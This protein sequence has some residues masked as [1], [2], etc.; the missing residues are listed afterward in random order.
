MTPDRCLGAKAAVNCRGVYSVTVPAKCA[1]SWWPRISC[2]QGW[3]TALKKWC[4]MVMH[5]YEQTY[6]NLLIYI[7]IGGDCENLILSTT[8][9]R[10]DMLWLFFC[11]RDPQCWRGFPGT[12]NSG[13]THFY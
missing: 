3:A 7:T 9:Q 11:A 12:A 1:L 5:N 10:P 8:I 6:R 13:A 2:L 4:T